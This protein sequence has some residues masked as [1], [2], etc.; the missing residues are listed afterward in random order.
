[1]REVTLYFSVDTDFA[2]LATVCNS[3][4]LLWNGWIWR[5]CYM[6]RISFASC[7]PCHDPARKLEHQA[8]AAP[9]DSSSTGQAL[10]IAIH[11]SRGCWQLP[12]QLTEGLIKCYRTHAQM[13]CFTTQ[14]LFMSMLDWTDIG[15]WRMKYGSKSSYNQF[16]S[17]VNNA[18]VM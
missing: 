10:S 16:S 9:C 4:Q 13:S 12:T 17:A 8:H 5:T 7:W 15:Q 2:T 3:L 14:T 1:M 11:T 18:D 6:I